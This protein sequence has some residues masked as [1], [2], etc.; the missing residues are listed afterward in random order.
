MLADCIGCSACEIA[1]KQEHSLPV[2]PRWIRVHPDGPRLI[3]G[4]PQLRYL[5]THCM[6]CTQP[7]CREVCPTEAI[8]KREDGIVLVNEQL[9]TGCKE[10]IDACPLGVMQFDGQTMVAQ[11]CDLCVAR[12][13]SGQKPACVTACPSH[14]THVGDLG[15]DSRGEASGPVTGSLGGLAPPDA[16]PLRVSVLQPAGGS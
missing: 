9:C 7:R 11:K 14:C 4:R 12:V 5:V 15:K 6:H 2:G 1:C 8:T 13:D 16:S 10:C 3:E